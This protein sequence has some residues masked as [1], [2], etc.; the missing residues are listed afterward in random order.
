MHMNKNFI[1]RCFV[2]VLGVIVNSF[3]I[4][5]ITKAMLGTSPI[6]SVPYVLSLK[7]AP[8]FGIFTFIINVGFVFL[9]FALLRK[10]FHKVQFLQLAV[11][12][13]FASCIDVSMWILS[14][15]VPPGFVIKF[16]SLVV[17]CAILGMGIV[18]EIYAKVLLVPGEGVVW[19][20]SQIFDKEMGTVKICFDVTLVATAI[21]ISF[22][23]FHGLNG[24][25][26]GTIVS[27]IAV[28]MF[29]KIFNKLF[30]PF[31]RWLDQAYA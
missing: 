20:I 1:L 24:L 29:V 13:I 22:I 23:F 26:L 31:E 3:G 11:T 8:T 14:D 19:T 18:L 6:S 15:F 4:A 5:F 2:F 16:V 17:G 10:D 9:Q 7:F 30:K 25:G 12:F 27:A 28:G 21:V